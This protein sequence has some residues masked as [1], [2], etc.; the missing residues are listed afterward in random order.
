MSQNTRRKAVR[1]AWLLVILMG[2]AACQSP[3]RDPAQERGLAALGRLPEAD[4]PC[5]RF[6]VLGDMGTGN[7]GQH[8]VARALARRASWEPLDLILTV[9]DNFYPA[10]VTSVDDPQWQTKFE[11]VYD[12]PALRAPFYPSLGN[13]DHKGNA[14]AQ[15]EYS[16]HGERWRMPAPYYTF[17]RELE[18]GLRV[19][20]FAI[21]TTALGSCDEAAQEQLAWL[22]A[23]LR[24]AED[25]DWRFVY[26]HHPLYSGSK[27]RRNPVLIEWLEPIL[28]EHQVDVY[29]A[30][31]DHV[32]QMLRP[33]HGI[34]HVIS[35]AGAGPEKAYAVEWTDE[36]IYAATLGGAVVVT[37][38]EET[39]TFEFVRMNGIV[40]HRETVERTR[41]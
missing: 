36:S 33:I 38:T 40:D 23:A 13:H 21:D 39:L 34:T 16:G 4:R 24:E 2:T 27:T 10:G 37:V 41:P 1:G 29:F 30:G 11:E 35:G 22:D 17:N 8:E 9:G 7:A 15:V 26:G 20:F 25:V 14:A 19:A 28:I 3:V 12:L 6:A 5:L 31:H 18:N 32:L